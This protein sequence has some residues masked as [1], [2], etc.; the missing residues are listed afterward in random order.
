MH[1]PH[2]TLKVAADIVH[3]NKEMG[4]ALA[5]EQLEKPLHKK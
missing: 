4:K 2:S 5:N 1:H 3:G